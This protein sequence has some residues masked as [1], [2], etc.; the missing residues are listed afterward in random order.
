MTRQTI[1][2]EDYLPCIDC[3]KLIHVPFC[4]DGPFTCECGTVQTAFYDF[5]YDD[6][7]GGASVCGYPQYME[8]AT[9]DGGS[10]KITDLVDIESLPTRQIT[11]DGPAFPT[12]IEWDTDEE[13]WQT[14]K[15]EPPLPTG[16]WQA[17]Y[18]P[19]EIAAAC[20]AN[21][22][23]T[24]ERIGPNTVR[25]MRQTHTGPSG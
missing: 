25:I 16:S 23:L 19:D 14:L 2:G 17:Q 12:P 10:R 3:G 11:L 4:Q 9:A 21:E 7:D 24:W 15:I 13:S 18:H 5:D 6:E 1:K 20:I 8:R 22:T